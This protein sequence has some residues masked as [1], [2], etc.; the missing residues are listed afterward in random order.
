MKQ[1]ARRWLSERLRKFAPFLWS[2]R[3][4]VRLFAPRQY[5]GAVGAV[6]NGA[7]KILLVEHLFR[8][9]FPWGLPGGW[10]EP[11]ENPSETVRRE[12][13]EE[14]HLEI[15]VKELLFSEQVGVVRKSA[16][17]S[18]LGLAFYCRLLYGEPAISAEIISF[19]WSDP[20]DIQHQLAPFQR[21][22]ALLAKDAFDRDASNRI[23][24]EEIG[25]ASPAGSQCNLQ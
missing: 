24:V 2:L 19:E 3:F 10:V 21:K 4:G 15:D 13:M 22:A 9:D 20:T 25:K 6:F 17:P 11:G 7:G 1:D 5:V 18:H 23:K 14:L 8:T 12:I 16:H